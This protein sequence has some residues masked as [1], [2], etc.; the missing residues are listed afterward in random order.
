VLL[1]SLPACARA[2]RLL[3][4]HSG[5]DSDAEGDEGAAAPGGGGDEA[6]GG[7]GSG[8]LA[9]AKRQDSGSL[10]VPVPEDPETVF[11]QVGLMD[12]GWS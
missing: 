5:Y 10:K 8:S 1:P 12:D 2:P 3:S 4:H 7:A 9:A 6:A 11:M